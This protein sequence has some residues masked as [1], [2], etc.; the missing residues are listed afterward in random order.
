MAAFGTRDHNH[1]D[2]KYSGP[3]H[4]IEGHQEA[5]GTQ[6][7]DIETSGSKNCAPDEGSLTWSML[8]RE[9]LNQVSNLVQKAAQVG[10][11]S[12]GPHLGT[13]PHGSL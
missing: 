3:Y 9:W 10:P 6:E 1:N 13:L 11:L 2:G 8:S 12:L 7:L 4:R 5:G